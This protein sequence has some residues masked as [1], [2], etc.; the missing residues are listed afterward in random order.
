MAQ[1]TLSISIKEARKAYWALIDNVELYSK[2]QQDSSDVY[3]LPEYD[4]NDPEEC[5]NNEQLIAD[6]D[7]QL[8]AAGVSEFEFTD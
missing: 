4:D 7:C 3:Y 1:T 2:I 6:I 5:D 8:C